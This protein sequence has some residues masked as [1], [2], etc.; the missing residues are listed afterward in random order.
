MA[1]LAGAA[2]VGPLILL[3]YQPTLEIRVVTISICIVVF[4]FIMTLLTKGQNSEVMAASAAYAAVL[5]VFVSNT[6]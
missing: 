1:L 6:S 4:C 3:T 5:S 2:L